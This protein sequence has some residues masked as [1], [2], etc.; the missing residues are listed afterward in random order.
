MDIRKPLHLVKVTMVSFR[1]L[2]RY[3]SRCRDTLDSRI[4]RKGKETDLFENFFGIASRFLFQLLHLT[5]Y[6]S[7]RLRK[8]G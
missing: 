7:G 8:R 5:L 1:S 6:F 2:P 4:R 3:Y